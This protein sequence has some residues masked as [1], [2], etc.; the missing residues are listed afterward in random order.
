MA[1]SKPPLH[2][3]R[4]FLCSRPKTHCVGRGKCQKTPRYVSEEW[5]LL[6]PFSFVSSSSDF[7]MQIWRRFL[8]GKDGGDGGDWR[9]KK[10]MSRLLSTVIAALIQPEKAIAAPDLHE[11]RS[12]IATI[13][14]TAVSTNGSR[15]PLACPSASAA[16]KPPP[17][18][19]APP[20]P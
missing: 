20:S 3:S 14:A 8:H 12:H 16:G 17:Q 6:I 1:R 13:T 11:R 15:C 4:K 2:I 19:P 7:F 10:K 5:L 18:F 9:Q